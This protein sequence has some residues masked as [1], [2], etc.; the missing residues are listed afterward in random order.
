MKRNWITGIIVATVA[1]GASAALGQEKGQPQ[2]DTVKITKTFQYLSPVYHIGQK[3]RSMMGPKSTEKI[4]LEPNDA[5]ELLWVTSM[6]AEMVQ[7]DGRSPSL[8]DFMCHTNLDVARET[9]QGIFRNMT[10][11]ITLS[12]GQLAMNLPEGFGIP[13]LSNEPLDIQ[14]QVLNHNLENPSADV[15]HKVTINY[16]RDR[17]LKTPLI[18]L[19]T[20]AA[21]GM[22]LVEGS[23]P[24]F[25]ITHP[26]PSVHGAGCEI[27]QTASASEVK[28]E[29]SQTKSKFTGHWVVP[30]GRNSYSTS[31]TVFMNVPYDTTLHYAEVH[32]HPF[33]ESA[34]LI[35]KTA[36]V[37]VIKSYAKNA[38][39]K[40]GLNNVDYFSSREGVPIYKGHEYELVSVYNNTSGQDQDAMAHMVLFLKDNFF[41]RSEINLQ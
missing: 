11:V 2:N 20:T 9:R 17:D 27:G 15:R 40:I 35:D 1:F 14:T 5:P 23:N 22:V 33:A 25:E 37:T 34:E 8:P 12:Q 30:P 4:V 31:S 41:D 26:N 21:Q 13:F 29:D 3:Y 24:Y 39:G 19:F 16:I 18:P 36:G 38:E 6:K 32:L 7:E 10:R 28:Y